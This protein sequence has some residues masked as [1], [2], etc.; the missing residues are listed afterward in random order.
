MFSLP[1]V[2]SFCPSH[3]IKKSD[4]WHSFLNV[5]IENK[6]LSLLART[7]LLVAERQQKPHTAGSEP[8]IALRELVGQIPAWH[9]GRS[10]SGKGS[11]LQEEKREEVCLQRRIQAAV[12]HHG[13]HEHSE[14]AG[15]KICFK[16]ALN[17]RCV[18]L[19]YVTTQLCLVFT[20][21]VHSVMWP[22]WFRGN[23]F[24]PTEWS[25]RLPA[26][27]SASC[28]PVNITHGHIQKKMFMLRWMDGFQRVAKNEQISD[29]APHHCKLHLKLQSRFFCKI[30]QI[31]F[32]YR[33]SDD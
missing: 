9:D 8:T 2:S 30:T 32:K 28:S 16:L 4:I 7:T 5:K 11:K 12:R 1:Q 23:T 13:R 15:A 22:W 18:C 6:L 3:P 21:R 33:L 25:S 17:G 10:V 20:S 27:S 31:Y 26:T 24:L 19:I 14:K 29:S